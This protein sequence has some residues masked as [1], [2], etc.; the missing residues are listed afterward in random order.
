VRAALSE[1]VR[2]HVRRAR[3]IAHVPI[4]RVDP[5]VGDGSAPQIGDIVCLHHGFTG[6][7]GEPMGIVSCLGSDGRTKWVADLLDSEIELIEDN[8]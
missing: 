3:V 8:S 4:E 2:R 1:A 6:S 7:T 5:T